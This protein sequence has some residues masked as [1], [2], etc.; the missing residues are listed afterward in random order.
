MTDDRAET[1]LGSLARAL[2][3]AVYHL[4]PA[5]ERDW[6]DLSAAEREEYHDAAV[7]LLRNHEAAVRAALAECDRNEGGVVTV[8]PDDPTAAAF[9]Q[10]FLALSAMRS[11]A[12]PGLSD[13][14]RVERLDYADRAIEE[15]RA[16][17]TGEPPIRPEP[18]PRPY[19][20]PVFGGG[21]GGVVFGERD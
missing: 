19:V 18:E 15:L 13:G 11:A 1:A 6:S 8:T 3:A 16:V 14:E 2:F 4:H 12:Q 10:V 21:G 20:V 7:G 17:L 9:A 5:D